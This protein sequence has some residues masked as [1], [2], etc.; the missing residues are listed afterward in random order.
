MTFIN[1][2][3]FSYPPQENVTW[4]KSSSASLGFF[5]AFDTN[6]HKCL[7]NSFLVTSLKTRTH[8]RNITFLTKA[9]TSR[10]KICPLFI[11][12]TYGQVP[13]YIHCLPV[14]FSIAYIINE[15]I[16]GMTF[17]GIWRDGFVVTL[18][19]VLFVFCFPAWHFVLSLF[20]PTL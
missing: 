10:T 2:V 5:F 8:F 16:T 3:V 17:P 13:C 11:V 20:L 4:M 19:W 14:L 7:G 6:D 9:K 1:I 15:K 18:V 12:R